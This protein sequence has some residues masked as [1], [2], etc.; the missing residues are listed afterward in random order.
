MNRGFTWW[1]LL[2][3]VGVIAVLAILL[4]HNPSNFGPELPSPVLQVKRDIFRLGVALELYMLD[5]NPPPEEDQ[6]E[7][8]ITAVF[9]SLEFS[10][11]DS[12]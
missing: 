7:K 2:I 12:I 9:E 6:D 4:D 1:G 5:H 10:E 3:V 11:K 8:Y